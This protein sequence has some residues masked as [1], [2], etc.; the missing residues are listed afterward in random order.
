MAT[1]I[2]RVDGLSTDPLVLG[3]HKYILNHMDHQ[4]YMAPFYLF[5]FCFLILGLLIK[6]LKCPP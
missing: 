4:A 5:L 2:P 3:R 1:C 6:L